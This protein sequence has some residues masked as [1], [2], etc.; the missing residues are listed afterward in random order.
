M[1][2][3]WLLKMNA[4]DVGH[5]YSPVLM[6]RAINIRMVMWTNVHSVIKELQKGNCRHVYPFAQQNVCISVIWTIPTVKYHDY[7]K[8]ENTRLLHLKQERNQKFI[9]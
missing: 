5:A 8:I 2:S 9:I 6:M 1:E 3:S 4:L 7:S